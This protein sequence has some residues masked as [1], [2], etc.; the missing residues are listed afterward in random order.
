MRIETNLRTLFNSQR[1]QIQD[2]LH[3]MGI[4]CHTNLQNS[5]PFCNEAAIQAVDSLPTPEKS[6]SGLSNNEVPPTRRQR[7]PSHPLTMADKLKL[8]QTEP[9]PDAKKKTVKVERPSTGKAKVKQP[10]AAKKPV[11]NQFRLFVGKLN[12][13]TNEE[14]IRSHFEKFGEI[15]DIYFPPGKEDAC[16]HRGY[17]FVTFSNFYDKHPGEQKYH[18]IDGR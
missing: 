15:T 8:S 6:P 12:S 4:Q 16:L 7:S 13:A 3:P 5:P 2:L 18:K 9:S 17:C 14:S 10:E 1:Q 11:G